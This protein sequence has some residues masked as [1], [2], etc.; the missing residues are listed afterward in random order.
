MD[1]VV[2]SSSATEGTSVCMKKMLITTT[3]SGTE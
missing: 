2:I 3:I 1:E